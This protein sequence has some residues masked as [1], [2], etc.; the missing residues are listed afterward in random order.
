VTVTP[1]VF[2]RTYPVVF[3]L[4]KTQTKSKNHETCRDIMVSCVEI[5][6]KI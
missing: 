6:I 4:Y 1:G 2:Q 5:V 3:K